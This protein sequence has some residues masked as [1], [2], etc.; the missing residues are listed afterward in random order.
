ME[1]LWIHP[2]F[3]EP[4]AG[5]QLASAGAI[6]QH[7][8]V[9]GD[10]ASAQSVVPSQGVYV[11]QVTL[12]MG[13]QRVSVFYKLYTEP[14]GSWRYVGRW[15]KARRET[16]SY[17]AFAKLGIRCAQ[18]IACSEQR[19][20][21]RRLR[22]A[23]LITVA[24]PD[25]MMLDEYIAQHCDDPRDSQANTTRR[26]LID[27][28]AAQVSC[29]HRASF[30]HNDLHWRNIIVNGPAHDPNVWWIDCPR[31]RVQRLPWLQR[32]LAVKDLACLDRTAVDVCSQSERMR[33]LLA[34][35]QGD[36]QRARQLA[37]AVVAYR[38]KRW[39]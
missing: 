22:S 23:F 38:R 15:S 24:V 37:R 4:L 32:R 13:E 1:R 8:G 20:R 19:D 26:A 9:A 18:W 39:R 5:Q 7:L 27:Q 30:F 12:R 14:S 25:A 17:D 10:D 35:A 21:F 6:Q 29:A 31:G 2:T 36:R 16:L 33:F 28:L 11:S 34:Y 3:A